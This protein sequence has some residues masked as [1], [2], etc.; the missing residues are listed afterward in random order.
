MT[1]SGY[2]HSEEYQRAVRAWVDE[3]TLREENAAIRDVPFFPAP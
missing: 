2:Q 1:H 3:V